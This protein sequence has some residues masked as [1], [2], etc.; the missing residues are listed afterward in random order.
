MSNV[1]TTQDLKLF[2]DYLYQK[3]KN[4]DIYIIQLQTN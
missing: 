3:F 2:Q 4:R 1:K